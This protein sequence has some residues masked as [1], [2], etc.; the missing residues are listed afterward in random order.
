MFS[1]FRDKSF[2]ISLGFA[3]AM[4]TLVLFSAKSSPVTINSEISVSNSQAKLQLNMQK[5]VKKKPVKKKK[6]VKKSKKLVAKKEV[7]IEQEVTKPQA[8]IM[9]TR[10]NK[11]S[12]HAP[13]PRYPRMAVKRGIEG[14]VVVKILIN[15]QGLP[16]EVS[17]LKS[18]GF[19]VLDDAAKKTAMQW[20]FSPALVDG[21]PV[22]SQN[23]QP[24]VF[25][26][27]NI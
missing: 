5:R 26:L 17:V 25:S 15:E 16:Y 10:L 18:S 23:H 13:K 22:K 3:L 12:M 2:Q 11:T 7:I 6:L 8:A 14:S 9:K 19:K 24:F 27:Q 4:H 1:I 20:K 21:K